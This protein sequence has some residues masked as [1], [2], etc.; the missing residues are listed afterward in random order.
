MFKMIK[1]GKRWSA[2]LVAAGVAVVVAMGLMAPPVQAAS[3][4]P[5]MVSLG[6]YTYVLNYGDTDVFPRVTAGDEYGP[7]YFDSSADAESI[8]IATRMDDGITGGVVDFYA[9]DTGMGWYDNMWLAVDG[10]DTYGAMSF[11]VCNP[12]ATGLTC[13]A[14][15]ALSDTNSTSI[16]VMRLADDFVADVASISVRVYDPAVPGTNY[17]EAD[18]VTIL[19]NTFYEDLNTN[20]PSALDATYQ[21]WY[22]GTIPEL[23]GISYRFYP[24]I[25]D[26]VESMT[27]DGTAYPNPISEGVWLYGVYQFDGTDWV[28][29][30]V[31]KY[32]GSDVYRLFEGDLV[33]WRFGPVEYYD[34]LLPKVLTDP[35]VS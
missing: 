12:L 13:P 14:A 32:A 7:T 30:E 27:V 11:G 6:D 24:G 8:E 28:R 19:A 23:S 2:S 33:V 22:N 18:G 16:T 4:D 5:Y 35:P 26:L 34:L 21:M 10:D 3:T 20:Y 9:A 15:P 17:Y 25:G 31:S 1:R 29:T